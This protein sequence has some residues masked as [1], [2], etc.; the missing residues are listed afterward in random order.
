MVQGIDAR[1]TEPYRAIVVSETHWDRAWYVPFETFRIRLVRLI[2]RVLDILDHDSEFRSFMLD[3]QMLPIEDYLEIRPERRADLARYAQSGR[4]VVGP[5]YVLADEYLVSPES[6]I[7]NLMV[8]ARMAKALGGFMGEGY[9]PDAFGHISQLP[10]I[11]AGT[12]LRSAIFWRGIGDEGAGLGNEF[13]WQSPD[14]ACEFWLC[15]CAMAITMRPILVT[16]CVGVTP[17]PWNSIL[18]SAWSNC[19]QP[20]KPSSRM[21]GLVTYC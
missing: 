17:A 21:R 12:N 16:Q 18:N 13:W 7:R 4:L 1:E 10:Q 2:D 3:G 6:L 15:T 11:F 8:G 14:G 9:V 20:W 19:R 5:W